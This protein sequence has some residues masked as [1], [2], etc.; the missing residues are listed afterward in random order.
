MTDN[1][2]RLSNKWLICLNHS[3]MSIDKLPAIKDY[4]EK[5]KKTL[6]ARTGSQKWYEI[7]YI[8]SKNNISS[9]KII[10][11]DLSS[12]MKFVLDSEGR[13]NNNTTY[14]IPNAQE[15]MLPILRSR[16]MYFYFNLNSNS[17]RGG[18]MRFYS[19]S[20]ARL[21]IVIPN[22]QQTQK[23]NEL[24]ND[25]EKQQGIVYDLYNV[26]QKDREVIDEYFQRANFEDIRE[27]DE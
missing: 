2:I 27:V 7:F 18:A 13:Y 17:F 19:H 5:H 14:F 12:S 24:W 8:A 1:A 9:K 4:L 26:S 11:A 20:I 16:L 25:Q 21:P 10:Y 3:P 6:Q 15:W 23:L 22:A